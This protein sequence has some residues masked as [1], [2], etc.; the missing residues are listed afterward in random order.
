MA[1][2]ARHI[3]LK[4]GAAARLLVHHLEAALLRIFNDVVVIT[5][6]DNIHAF[7]YDRNPARFIVI[8][9]FLLRAADHKLPALFNL[10]RK[11]G[12]SSAWATATADRNAQQN[13]RQPRQRTGTRLL[14]QQA[15]P[16]H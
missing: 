10:G 13:Q 1:K 4:I 2:L 5:V 14:A 11:P 16:G 12:I 3:T 15:N 7:I 9:D 6:V 8:T